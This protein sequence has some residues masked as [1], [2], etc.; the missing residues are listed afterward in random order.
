MLGSIFLLFIPSLKLGRTVCRPF[1]NA[2]FSS[3]GFGAKVDGSRKLRVETA[4]DEKKPWEGS[5]SEVNLVVG[6]GVTRDVTR[7]D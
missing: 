6:F 1:I 7:P 4:V 3:R 2:I 5:V